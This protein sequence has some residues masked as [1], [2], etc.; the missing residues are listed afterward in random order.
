MVVG[1]VGECTVHTGVVPVG[2]HWTVVR[3]CVVRR[4]QGVVGVPNPGLE[5]AEPL[6]PC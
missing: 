6:V 3:G 5:A 2:T 4:K 1:A